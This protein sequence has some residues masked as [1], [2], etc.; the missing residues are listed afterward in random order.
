MKDHWKILVV[1]PIEHGVKETNASFVL[2]LSS[3]EKVCKDLPKYPIFPKQP[4]HIM[5]TN[6]IPFFCGYTTSCYK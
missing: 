1:G 6:D 5:D 2:D 3:E 4:A